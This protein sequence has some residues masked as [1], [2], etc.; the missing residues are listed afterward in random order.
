MVAFFQAHDKTICGIVTASDLNDQF[1]LLAEPFL[2][3]GE[4]QNGVSRMLHGKFTKSELEAS[5]APDDNERQIGRLVIL[6]L[7]NTSG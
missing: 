5:K 3:V 4:I 7:E 2:L 1:L 6:H